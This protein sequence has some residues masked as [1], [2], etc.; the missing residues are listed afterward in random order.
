MGY[1]AW[2]SAS[3]IGETNFTSNIRN[4]RAESNPFSAIDL[5]L[6]INLESGAGY[7]EELWVNS[8]GL[9]HT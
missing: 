7:G 8:I 6:T 4:R 2:D 5:I 9:M 3:E 1:V